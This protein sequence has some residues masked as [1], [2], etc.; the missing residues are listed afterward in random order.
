MLDETPGLYIEEMHTCFFIR[1]CNHMPPK[2]D[3]AEAVAG[4]KPAKKKSMG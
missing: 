2:L 1:L 3:D 4:A